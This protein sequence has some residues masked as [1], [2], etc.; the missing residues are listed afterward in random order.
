MAIVGKHV[1]LAL[2]VSLSPALQAQPAS[3]DAMDAGLPTVITPTRLLQSLSDVP[4]SVTVITAEILQLLGV[5]SIPDALRLVP[6]MAMTH[7]TGPD[8][9][10][11]YH[12]TNTLSPRRMNVL[13]DGVSVYR[14][15]FSEVLWS[16]LPINIDE[17]DRIE[18]TRGPSSAS[19][20]PNSMLAVIN[21]ITRSAG[22]VGAGH[23]SLTAAH[24]LANEA[25]ARMGMRLGSTALSLTASRAWDKGFDWLS[26]D[27]QGHDS[28]SVNRLG[29]RLD[30]KLSGSD[31]IGLRAMLARGVAEIP[32]ID[33]FQLNYPDRNFS[34]AYV[35]A[36]WE[37]E[38]S[39]THQLRLSLDSARQRNR[40]SWRTCLPT[41]ALL[42]QLFDLWRANPDYANAIL[43][44][45]VPIGSGGTALDDQLALAAIGALRALGTAALQP[46]CGTTDQDALQ[47]RTDLE[48]QDTWVL[49]PGY[50]LVSGLGL[51]HQGG[52]SRTFLGGREGSRVRWAFANLEARP[53]EWLTLNFGGYYEDNSLAPSSFSP[54]L[55]AN[56]HL[57]PGH[58]LRASWSKG[59]RSPDIQEQRTNWTFVFTELAP[60]LFG[61]TTA[62]F[63]QSRVGPGGLRSE[64]I[65][66]RELGYVG[67]LPRWGL[68]VDARV[69]DDELT[70]LISERT[71]LAGL[72]PTNAGSVTLRGAELQASGRL[73]PQWFAHA[74]YAY[75]DNRYPTNILERTLWS[76]HSG[77]IALSRELTG[78]WQVAGRYT[79][80][81]G[82][83]HQQSSY[84][85]AD[86]VVSQAWK[87]DATAWRLTASLQRLDQPDISY[88]IGSAAA[89]ESRYNGR[90]RGFVQLAV[91]LP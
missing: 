26:Q 5:R 69:F 63:Y 64:R 36:Q 45:R 55:A 54:R 23:L 81:S 2:L 68:I 14:P 59:T 25:V 90:T 75:L 21:I 85:R 80:A 27:A 48:L 15:A 53:R 83:G 6:G 72:R 4:A 43:A 44:G 29:L 65:A 78:G 51:R 82:D 28:L 11:S 38:I 79:G 77:S 58:T 91:D 71:N 34:D 50:R 70:D 62:R 67:N 32:F 87:Q 22:D 18:V 3:G 73:S 10:I 47:F 66:S 56:W 40:Q 20:G 60:P 9:Q 30:G 12:G 16:Q 24:R 49:S 52:E 41:A 76:R 33:R 1:A 57:A 7:A 39:A 86:L 19:Y 8:Y 35:S 88:S 37:R 17:I 74:T 84:G 61:S 42:P 46:R 13:I 31:A 89:L